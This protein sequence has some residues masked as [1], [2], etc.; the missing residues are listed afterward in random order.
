MFRLTV[1]IQSGNAAFG[2]PEDSAIEAR[3]LL[4]VAADW[5]S[6]RAGCCDVSKKLMDING[7]KC[8]VVQFEW[9]DQ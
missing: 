6:D 8:G 2:S 3:R 9:T 4:L 1:M 7:N 5:I